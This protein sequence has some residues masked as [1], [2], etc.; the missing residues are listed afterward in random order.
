M[1]SATVA[2]YDIQNA[3]AFV[4]STLDSSRIRFASEEREELVLEGLAVLCDLAG[5]FQPHMPGY[6]Q[7]GRFSGY[8]A[9]FLPRRLGEA[10]HRLHP[11]HVYRTRADGS[12]EWEYLQPPISLD[13]ARERAGYNGSAD[14]VERRT[15]DRTQWIR[16]VPRP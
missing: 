4:R 15:L 7:P 11:E 2:L 13:G 5:S 3:E 10:W 12:R 1:L 8:A 16:P 14:S 6:D 9:R